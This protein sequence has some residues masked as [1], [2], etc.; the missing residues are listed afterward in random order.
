LTDAHE[1]LAELFDAARD[2]SEPET[3]AFVAG[4]GASDRALADDLRDL[5]RH[6]RAETSPLDGPLELPPLPPLSTSGGLVGAGDASRAPAVNERVGAFRVLRLLGEGG[7]GVVYLAEQD[8]PRREVALKII[9][10]DVASP[11]ALRRFEQESELLARLQ[12]R[13]IAQVLAAGSVAVLGRER[14]YFALEYVDG[15]PLTR[16]ARDLDPRARVELLRSVCEA[17][18]HA[19]ERGVVHR[20][21]KPSN[22]LVDATGQPKVLDF[23]IARA[24]GEDARTTLCTRTGELLGTL[25]Y[26]APEQ[27]DGSG[28]ADA[29]T[30]VYALGVIAYELLSGE[31]PL[32]VR[33]LTLAA[34][35]RVVLED[36]PRPLARLR[37]DLHGDLSTIVAK[38]LAK[39]PA[40]RYASARA[41]ADDLGRHLEGRTIRARPSTGW[42]HL[43]R[44]ARRN[45]ALTGAYV[46]LLVASLAA[47]AISTRF[48]LDARDARAAET[49]RAEA[50]ERSA[51]VASLGAAARSL[52]G[53]AL[54]AARRWLDEVPESLRDGFEARYYAA[55]LD[56]SVRRLVPTAEESSLLAL[57]MQSVYAVA[58]SPGGDVLAAGGPGP[59]VRLWDPETGEALGE[60]EGHANTPL[61]TAFS[62]DGARLHTV[63]SDGRVLRFDLATRAIDA[64]LDLPQQARSL[65]LAP[66]GRLL[67][68]G[69][70]DGTI[71]LFDAEL[72]PA[73]EPLAGHTDAVVSLAFD[74]AGARLASASHDGTARVFDVL[75]R[76]TLAVFEA[77]E[78]RV[79]AVAFLPGGRVASGSADETVRAWA[80]ADPSAATV[81]RMPSRVYC[82]QVLPGGER[83][84]VGCADGGLRLVETTSDR[85]LFTLNGHEDP[86]DDMVLGPNGLLATGGGMQAVRLWDVS[87]AERLDRMSMD[88]VK[89]YECVYSPD[90]ATIVGA[91]R[92]GSLRAWDAR[93]GVLLASR[94][95]DEVSVLGLMHSRDGRR[96]YVGY[97]DGR[98][99]VVDAATLEVERELNFEIGHVRDFAL[100]DV[101]EHELLA[102]AG[103]SVLV[104]STVDWSELMRA[105]AHGKGDYG[106]EFSPDGT[107]LVAAGGDGVIR[108]YDVA[109]GT[110]LSEAD[111]HEWVVRWA[112][113]SPDGTRAAS[114]SFDGTL[115]MRDPET[116]APLGDPL[117]HEGPLMS[118]AFS[119]DGSRLAVGT[120]DGNAW[121]WEVASGTLLAQLEVGRLVVMAVEFAPDGG[122]LIATGDTGV[123]VFDT[124]PQ[125]ERALA[126]RR[127]P[128]GGFLEKR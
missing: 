64:R 21:L 65:A 11:A 97:G 92:D 78:A 89:A 23:G 127:F 76:T 115:R 88:G 106:V 1:R 28:E 38:A 27:L 52:D 43:R 79:D 108:L 114:I 102:L 42:D 47:T 10:P 84:L 95:G 91:A 50:A 70:G 36:E 68:I 49:E 56:D 19:H 96:I 113:Y 17:V 48:W 121:I 77:H 35:A 41:L 125:G 120:Q 37:P 100:C 71:A 24:I 18:Q 7:M 112:G 51:Y 103:D 58:F 80:V 12:H 39:E 118:A 111:D 66:D 116:F 109:S 26:M 94:R 5:L 57:H 30:D 22:I 59:V 119:P 86:I 32:D 15:P 104:V 45:P 29:R 81:V 99:H 123:R 75:E 13:G 83:M 73:G 33:G 126:R 53:Y 90:G 3:D 122:A 69:L 44:F 74:E 124:A 31:L 2:L 25:A 87:Q 46:A 60:L 110:V 34:A 72:R 54:D 107:R 105:P 63:A 62:P 14:S 85:P 93:S 8:K 117:R 128:G 6:H 67:A 98:T 20:D 9:R 61:G 101:G 4:L 16:F 40:D 82:L 55:R